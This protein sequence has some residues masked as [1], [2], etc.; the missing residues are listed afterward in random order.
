[1]FHIPAHGFLKMLSRDLA[2]FRI[3]AGCNRDD[4]NSCVNHLTEVMGHPKNSAKARGVNISKTAIHKG[5]GAAEDR[6]PREAKND[7]KVLDVLGKDVCDVGD[8]GGWNESD[9]EEVWCTSR[10]LSSIVC[11]DRGDE[12]EIRSCQSSHFYSIRPG[13]FMNSY[14][15]GLDGPQ[16][17]WACRKFNSHRTLP[18]DALREARARV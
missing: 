6:A 1:M 13:R 18:S 10:D 12:E 5:H 9:E 8:Q 11:P 2:L 15:D 16:A 3:E 7:K 4:E 14:R 17:A